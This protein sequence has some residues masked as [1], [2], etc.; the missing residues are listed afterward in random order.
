MKA[1]LAAD[2]AG[3]ATETVDVGPSGVVGQPPRLRVE[4]VLLVYVV[5]LF[6]PGGKWCIHTHTHTQTDKDRNREECM[7]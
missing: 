5:V 2:A 1:G 7:R 6:V 4:R 3:I